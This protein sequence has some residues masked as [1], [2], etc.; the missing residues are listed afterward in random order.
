MKRILK[1]TRYL[2]CW[3]LHTNGY[4]YLAAT[5]RK[6]C[7][8]RSCP[9]VC[10]ADW[11]QISTKYKGLIYLER[12]RRIAQRLNPSFPRAM[13]AESGT[14]VE[15]DLSGAT[16]KFSR[17]NPDS[18]ETTIRGCSTLDCV[19]GCQK[20]YQS[21][22][23]RLKP[24]FD[25][26]LS[27]NLGE[28]ENIMFK[29]SEWFLRGTTFHE[30]EF[31]ELEIRYRE[32]STESASQNRTVSVSIKS[33]LVCEKNAKH[34]QKLGTVTIVDEIQIETITFQGQIKSLRVMFR[35]WTYTKMT[36]PIYSLLV[37][38]AKPMFGLVI[39]QFLDLVTRNDWLLDFVQWLG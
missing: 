30:T 12:T 24:P 31:H 15:V 7:I 13:S 23:Q 37:G 29:I 32:S 16:N 20:Q 2:A 6:R 22:G 11:R 28:M 27:L 35:S 17:R 34:F 9:Q 38:L 39:R 25:H 4:R 5:D 26:Q 8:R 14:T 19:R 36:C 10:R 3:A 1:R 21:N 33:T 18:A